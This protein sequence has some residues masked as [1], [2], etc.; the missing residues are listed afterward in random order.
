MNEDLNKLKSTS[1]DYSFHA[2]RVMF[3]VLNGEVKIGPKNTSESHIEWFKREGWLTDETAEDFLKKNI[4]GFYLPA[5]DK[6]YV[7]RG[8]G[9]QFDQQTLPELM[10]K[11]ED[12][13]KAFGLTGKTKICLGPKDSPVK[14][15][16]YPRIC[17]GTV[18]GLTSGLKVTLM[19][20][21]GSQTL[22]AA[23]ALGCFE[24]KSS[25]ELFKE[26][27]NLPE[28]ERKKKEKA[29]LKN[30]FG[31]GHGSVGD[32]TFF[33]YSIE[34]LPRLTTLQLCLPEY[35]AHLQQSLRRAQATRGVYLPESIKSSPLAKEAEKLAAWTFDFYNR[36]QQ[37]A[38]PAEDSRFPLELY[39]KTNISTVLDAREICHLDYM[40][41]LPGVPAIT[42]ETVEDMMGQAKLETP[43]MLQN[44][45]FNFEPLSWYPSS[46]LFAET[47]QTM[48]QL[49]RKKGKEQVSFL[50]YVCPFKITSEMVQRAVGEKNEAELANL[51]HAH[52]EFLVSMSL[53]CFHQATRQRTWNHSVESIYDAVEDALENPDNRI[54]IP[55]SIQGSQFLNEY[56]E[57]HL[58][59]INLYKR[60]VDIGIPK[61]DAIG[62]IPHSLKIYSL[63]HIN[64]WNAIHSIGKRTCNEA[65]WEIRFIARIMAKYIKTAEP[66]FGPWAEPQCITYGKC[67][68]VKDCGYYKA[69]QKS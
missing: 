52:F 50:G 27:N 63:I 10:E 7:Y 34:N 38:I 42:T 23:A 68:E 61:S 33:F 25:E 37:A 29:V 39:T 5:E 65:Q 2:S 66:A 21:T 14:D 13:K 1:E 43:D 49:I 19:K 56:K 20:T 64:G 31:R 41:H 6:L 30:S 32:Q 59:L 18:N 51:K 53:A 54:V 40:S 60:L 47:N 36:T 45:G 11:M 62:V 67:P 35:P 16:E 24:E 57:I 55:P 28:A 3:C 26:L 46:Q 69:K 58:S 44:Y 15:V 22:A 48:R 9:F 17:A 12:F 8:V 4:R